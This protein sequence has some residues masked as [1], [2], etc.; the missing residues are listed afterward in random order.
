M[1]LQ[2][3]RR[4]AAAAL[5]FAAGF[6]G[7][8]AAYAAYPDRPVKI[9]LPFPAGTVTDNTTRILAERL[10]KRLGATFIVDNRPGGNGSIGALAA[11]RSAPDGYT[12]LFT[13]NT[14]H[15]VI[16]SLLKKV[17]YDP[18][19]DFTPVAKVAGLPS[20]I[21]AGPA[22]PV[23]SIQEFVNYAKA[24]PGKVRYGFGNSSGQIGGANLRRAIGVEMVPVPYKGNPQGVQDLMGGHLEAMV[25]DVSTGLAAARSGKVRALAVL[26]DK[27]MDVLPEVPT[28]DEAM[29]PGNDAIAWFG[30]LGPAGLPADVV[31]VL[32][33][34][35][36]SALDDPEIIAKL[37]GMGTLPSY[38]PPAS[39]VPFLASE[40]TR[41]TRLAHDAG[42]TPE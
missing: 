13:T 12:L 29:G 21:L 3:R 32:A 24:N 39:F 37:K 22:L 10:S 23:V 31:E 2:L 9:I 30:V 26:T 4:F 14:T 1:T 8:Q 7:A 36:K 20:M 11:A 19:R 38:L 33:R 41:W 15:S 40:Q 35:L 16:S 34:E 25:V 42:I 17:P 18:Q 6:F 27:R 5:F 28:L